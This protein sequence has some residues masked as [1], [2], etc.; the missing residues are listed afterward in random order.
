MQ[1]H[2]HL[3]A[4]LPQLG[5][6]GI[7]AADGARRTVKC[8]QEA[9]PGRLDLPAPEPRQLPPHDLLVF[10]QEA[11]P[12][13][14]AQLGRLPGG[15]H[16][17]GEQHGGQHPVGIGD[18]PGTGQELLGQHDDSVLVAQER[19]VVVAGQLHDTGIGYPLGHIAAGTHVDPLVPGPVQQQVGTRTDPSSRRMSTGPSEATPS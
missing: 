10:L 4:Q 18:R 14:V 12:A 13:A 1:P 7:G 17:V 6:D 15:V 9:V 3:Q 5:P 8:G 19:E 16:D 11:M 2:P